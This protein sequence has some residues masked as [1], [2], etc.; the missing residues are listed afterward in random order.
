MGLYAETMASLQ[1]GTKMK[2]INEVIKAVESAWACP[3]S[4][5]GSEY[6]DLMEV[7]DDVLHYLKTIETTEN[8]YHDAI[9]E[10]SKWKDEDWKDRCLPLTWD[11][12]R[13]MEYYP[14]FVE[15]SGDGEWGLNDGIY[16]DAFGHD[17]V[18]IK[19]LRGLWHLDKEQMG[20]IWQAY[21][22]ERK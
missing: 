6:C 22:K 14:V 21:R 19:V 7:R 9:N 4:E 16:V 3:S 11:E 12:L 5:E 18:T 15:L 17:M 1:E 20:K 10:L 13:Q 8:L 2:T